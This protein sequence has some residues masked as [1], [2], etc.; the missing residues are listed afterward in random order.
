MQPVINII[1]INNFYGRESFVLVS[2]EKFR[3]VSLLIECRLNP[4]PIKT[5]G[6]IKQVKIIIYK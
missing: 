5:E 2:M 1:I 6:I 4:I 3:L